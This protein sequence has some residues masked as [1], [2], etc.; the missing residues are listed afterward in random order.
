MLSTCN[1]T[2]IYAVVERFHDSYTG[3]RE[4]LAAQAYV[5]PAEVADHLT[6]HS[7]DEAAR[8]LFEVAAGLDSAVVGET[9]ILSQIKSAWEAARVEGTVGPQLNAIFRHALEVGKRAR[10]ETAIVAAH[11]L[12]LDGGRCDGRRPARRPVGSQG[13]GRRCR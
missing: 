12:R 1:R 9:E 11:R 5:S 10:T 2:E 3:L 7:D 4:A 8:H 13:A 6:L